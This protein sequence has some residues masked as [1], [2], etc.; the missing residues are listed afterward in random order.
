[1]LRRQIFQDVAGSAERSEY[2]TGSN[3]SSQN[4][5]LTASISCSLITL[6][7]A[8]VRSSRG[9]ARRWFYLTCD[10]LVSRCA[11]LT[12]PFS[13]LPHRETA[14]PTDSDDRRIAGG[15]LDAKVES[16]R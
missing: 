15:D 9:V 4:C 16:H 7:S 13:L 12:L 2:F 1:M 14:S 10:G 8:Q 3:H 11:G 5:V 6:P